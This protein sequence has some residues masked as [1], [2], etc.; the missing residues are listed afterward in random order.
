MD[1]FSK[2]EQPGT[3]Q[4][5][6]YERIK[7]LL[8]NGQLEFG[9]VYSANHFAEIL[10]VSR[11]PI[12]EALLQLTSEGFFVS[13]RGR[14]FK[15]KEFSE[16]EIQDFFEARKMIEAYVIEQL[17]DEVSAEDLK[18]L[19]DS[20]AQMINGHKKIE[21]YR[22]LEA[23]KSF[24]MNLIRRYENSLLESIMGNI[25]DFISILG[26]KALASPGRVQEVIRE[27]QHILEA[28]HQK[29]RMKAVQAIQNHLDA[30]EKSL[31]EN[32]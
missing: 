27:H 16:K 8:I 6:A 30:T 14:G 11:T 12:R 1:N 15:I 26:Q 25:R 32:L 10:G 29:D 28:L 20:L 23:D 13:L 31:L 18:P 4:N 5:L 17:V 19:D 21:T 24:H 3:L 7:T 2:L 22:F 9:E